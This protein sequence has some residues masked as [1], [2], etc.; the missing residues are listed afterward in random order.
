MGH[1]SGPSAEGGCAW[2]DAT[3]LLG[4][5]AASKQPPSAEFTQ[6]ALDSH[7]GPAP[8]KSHKAC[9]YVLRA[10][11]ELQLSLSPAQLRVAVHQATN[12]AAVRCRPWLPPR[13]CFSWQTLPRCQC[14][15]EPSVG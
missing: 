4:L 13:P 11:A 6:T 3:S 2:Q 1:A 12:G 5:F 7:F 9:W 8:P 15:I 10:C 14:C